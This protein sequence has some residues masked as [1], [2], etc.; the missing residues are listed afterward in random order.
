MENRAKLTDRI[1][2]GVLTGIIALLIGLILFVLLHCTTYKT[3]D[4]QIFH[5]D[6]IEHV[7]P[8]RGTQIYLDNG[9]KVQSDS[10]ISLCG[11]GRKG[12]DYICQY[13]VETNCFGFTRNVENV[14]NRYEV[15]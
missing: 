3:T 4:V 1:E 8:F 2:Q 15:K 9:I 11:Y 12:K 10:Y 7:Y 13:R 5:T 14:F 6:E